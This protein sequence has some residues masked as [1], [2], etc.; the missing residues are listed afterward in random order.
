M[1]EVLTQAQGPTRR[2]PALGSMRK[3]ERIGGTTGKRK[4][5][6]QEDP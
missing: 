2:A 6:L 1:V 5:L 3:G 4:M